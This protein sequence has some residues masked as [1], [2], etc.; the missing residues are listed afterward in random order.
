MIKSFATAQAINDYIDS[1]I[2]GS[3][4]VSDID[5]LGSY[6]KQ[7]KSG[8]KYLE[9]GTGHGKSIASAIW[10]ASEEITFLTIDIEDF[11][12]TAT[13][14]M[15]RKEFFESEGLN[16][17]CTFIKDKSLNVAKNWSQGLFS[18]IFIDA[19]HTYEDGKA[20]ILAWLPKLKQGGFMVFH[21]YL[22]PQFTLKLAI[23]E[24]VRNSDLFSDFKVAKDLGF[25]ISSMAGA[26]KI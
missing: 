4:L 20:D 5:F 17:V 26:I 24:C 1:K 22:D 3:F 15:S 14:R 21:D 8:D 2:D 12:T 25:G 11:S 23:D 16:T 18:M 13:S 6:V 10:Q 9:I 19:T 7:L